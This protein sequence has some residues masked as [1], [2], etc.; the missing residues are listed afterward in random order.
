MAVIVFF[1]NGR[2]KSEDDV[3]SPVWIGLIKWIIK[4]LVH[5]LSKT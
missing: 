3:N 4:N 5:N 2:F 1:E